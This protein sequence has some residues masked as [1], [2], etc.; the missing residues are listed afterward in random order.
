MIKSK[1]VT[2]IIDRAWRSLKSHLEGCSAKPGILLLE[3]RI[4]SAQWFYWRRGRDLWK[5][6][7]EAFTA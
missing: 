2:Q 4:R 5:V 7:G 6:L 3:A 1:A